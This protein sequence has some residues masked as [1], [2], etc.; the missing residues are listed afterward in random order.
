MILRLLKEI[1]SSGLFD[2][3]SLE[4]R[5]NFR[6][7]VKMLEDGRLRVVQGGQTKQPVLA[8]PEI[9]PVES[10]KNDKVKEKCEKFEKLLSGDGLSHTSWMKAMGFDPAKDRA[11]TKLVYEA[12]KK[13]YAV[14]IYKKH[15]RWYFNEQSG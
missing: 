2:G 5:D 15:G 9:E 11:K 6:D 10:K 14:R 7:V 4:T 3:L 1:M 13:Q 8:E 12:E